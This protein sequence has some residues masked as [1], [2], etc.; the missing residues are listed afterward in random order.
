MSHREP[1]MALDECMVQEV[2]DGLIAKSLMTEAPGGEARA[3]RFSL[4]FSLR[5][6]CITSY[7]AWLKFFLLAWR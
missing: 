3:L 4:A 5:F 6:Q 7:K 1:V 2:S